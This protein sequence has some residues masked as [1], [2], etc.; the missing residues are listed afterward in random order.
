L[1]LTV[2]DA[3]TVIDEVPTP[4]SWNAAQL[5]GPGDQVSAWVRTPVAAGLV[6]TTLAS[7]ALVT[8]SV[9]RRRAPVKPGAAR[10]A[11]LAA[12]VALASFLVAGVAALLLAWIGPR[13]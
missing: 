3:I 8:S 1:S 12:T 10:L 7:V 5:E 9:R 2:D 13:V 6:S 11:S 4:I